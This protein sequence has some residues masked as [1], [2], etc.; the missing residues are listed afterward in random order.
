MLQDENPAPIVFQRKVQRLCMCPP[1]GQPFWRANCKK[2]NPPTQKV[3]PRPIV[4][5]RQRPLPI[6][7]PEP[8]LV[9]S[10]VIPTTIKTDHSWTQAIVDW[11][12]D[13]N[14]PVESDD[15]GWTSRSG[16]FFSYV[17]E[18]IATGFRHINDTLTSLWG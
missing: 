9:P 10:E 4:A 7:A 17:G 15:N 1:N 14:T 12:D 13:C 2:C 8:R 16:S 18:R 6:P 11:L 5:P 3:N